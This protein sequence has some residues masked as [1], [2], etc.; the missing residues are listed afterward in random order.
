MENAD[1]LNAVHIVLVDDEPRIHDMISDIL[2]KAELV[3]RIESFYDPLSFIEYLRKEDASPDLVLLDVHFENS[4]LSG[5]DI[6][7]FIREN[8]PCLPIVLLTGMEGEEIESAQDYECV[9]FIPKPVS[10]EHLV[11]MVRFYLGMGRKSAQRTA[12]LSRNLVEHKELVK[13]LKTELAQAEIS[14]WAGGRQTNDRRETRA[15]QRVLEILTTVLN[16]C[17]LMPSFIHDMEK[18]F[19]SDFPLLKKA[20]DTVIRFDLTDLTTPGLNVHKYKGVKDVYTLRITKKARLFF[21]QLQHSDNKRLRLIRIDPE[22]DTSG[23]DKWLKANCDTYG[24]LGC[25]TE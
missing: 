6:I 1:V 5:V 20:V 16:N 25:D 19:D 17:E 4:G 13:L 14:S 12:E 21:C 7:P 2:E 3:K 23:M 22:H 18:L 11:R 15:F 10:P 9:Y 24:V 8:H